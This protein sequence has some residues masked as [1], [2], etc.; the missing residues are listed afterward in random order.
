LIQ[1]ADKDFN[2]EG[3]SLEDKYEAL[4]LPEDC[5]TVLASGEN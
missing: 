3:L 4:L 1:T 2:R 5:L